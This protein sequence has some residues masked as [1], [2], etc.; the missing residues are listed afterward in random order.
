[1]K[2]VIVLGASRLQIPIIKQAKQLGY[3]VIAVDKDKNA[4]GFKY[5]DDNYPV[6]TNDIEEVLKI[7]KQEKIDGIITAATDTPMNTVAVVGESLNLNTISVET[8]LSCTNK[9]LMRERL[10]KFNV[11]IPNYSVV[12]NYENYKDA[13]NLINGDKII[14]PVDSS[15][16]RGVYFLDQLNDVDKAY[17]YAMSNSKNNEILVEEYMVGREVSVE[18]ITIKNET[19]IIAITDKITSGSPHFIELGH[20]VQSNLTSEIKSSV[21]E[22]TKNAVEAL[23]ITIGPAHTEI[24]ITKDGPKIVEVGAR[25]GGDNITSHLVPLATN[26]NILE[27]HILQSLGEKIKF[28]YD[29]NSGAAIKYINSEAG[30]LEN[31]YIPEDLKNDEEVIEI[32]FNYKSGDIVQKTSN[33]SNRMGHV[34]VKSD[35]AD[36]ALR[37]CDS[38]IDKIKFIYK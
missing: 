16:S 22:V 29:V 30:Q 33:S 14:K 27:F 5:S 17:K 34:I 26:N 15:G 32:M 7:S 6:S 8:A 21:M 11:P 38:I 13:L 25:L 10:K 12:R 23:G 24:I 19:H 3:Y 37:K 36:N 31:I 28:N 20:S 18:S 2:K 35:N 1:M 9:Y 4:E